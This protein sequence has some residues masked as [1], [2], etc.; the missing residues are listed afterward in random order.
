MSHSPQ[1]KQR[2]VE[3]EHFG[4]WVSGERD[5]GRIADQLGILCVQ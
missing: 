3:D 4:R 1:G 2:D 5:R